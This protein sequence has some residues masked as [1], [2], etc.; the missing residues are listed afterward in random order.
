MHM[1]NREKFI[2]YL[3]QSKDYEDFTSYLHKSGCNNTA[4][5]CIYREYNTFIVYYKSYIYNM[6]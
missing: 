6:K 2:L 1:N 4:I 5:E 3:S